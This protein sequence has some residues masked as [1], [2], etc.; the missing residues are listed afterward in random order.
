MGWQE[1]R[2]VFR[3]TPL[4]EVISDANRFHSGTIT[5]ANQHLADL[6]ITTSFRIEQ[7]Q[8]MTQMLE[9]ILPVNVTQTGENIVISAPPK[10][11]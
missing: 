5:L 2:L 4:I 10:K 7:I 8:E 9:S 1:G 11:S 3:N 6:R